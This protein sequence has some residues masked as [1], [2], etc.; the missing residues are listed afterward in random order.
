LRA[1]TIS[2]GLN[3]PGTK[4]IEAAAACCSRVSIENRRHGVAEPSGQGGLQ[5]VGTADG[6]RT[7]AQPR[8]VATQA[9]N[10]VD[11]LGGE[12]H[13]QFHMTKALTLQLFQLQAGLFQ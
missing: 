8:E 12:L 13:R 2:V 10:H 7:K 6:G 1:A 9:A 3:T 11:P 5:T 4:V